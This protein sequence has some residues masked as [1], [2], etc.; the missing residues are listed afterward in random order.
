MFLLDW[1]QLN[2]FIDGGDGDDHLRLVTIFMTIFVIITVKIRFL[3][4][5]F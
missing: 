5:G 2:A 1:L 3:K 4:T